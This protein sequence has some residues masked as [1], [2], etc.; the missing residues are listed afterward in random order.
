MVFT[1]LVQEHAMR[2]CVFF[3]RRFVFK[4]QSHLSSPSH[5][6][7]FRNHGMHPCTVDVTMGGGSTRGDFQTLD[8]QNFKCPRSLWHPCQSPTPDHHLKSNKLAGQANFLLDSFQF[9]S[10]TIPFVRITLHPSD[11]TR[12]QHVLSSRNATT[13]IVMFFPFPFAFQFP[14][15]SFAVLSAHER[16]KHLSLSDHL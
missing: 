16:H 1:R 10:F 5:S 3:Y 7:H 15:C 11:N 9:I 14:A 12:Q 8:L 4:S 2:L 13:A 6:A